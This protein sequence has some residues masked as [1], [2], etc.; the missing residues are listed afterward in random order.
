MPSWPGS[1]PALRHASSTVST[2]R[3]Q[4]SRDS[5]FESDVKAADRL[6]ESLTPD[7]R[8]AAVARRCRCSRSRGAKPQ[9]LPDVAPHWQA[10]ARPLVA[11]ALPRR[12][13]R[14]AAGAK[15]EM[16]RTTTA[17]RS[18]C[19]AATCASPPS[20]RAAHAMARPVALFQRGRRSDGTQSKSTSSTSDLQ[21][22]SAFDRCLVSR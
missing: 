2:F 16:S 7:S 4:S 8:C 18:S 6:A 22:R 11:D 5:Q 21:E 13:A 1:T 15:R 9:P 3:R 17:W 10:V 14:P 19:A 12:R 20:V